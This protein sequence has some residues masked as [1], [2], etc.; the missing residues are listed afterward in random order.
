MNVSQSSQ[1]FIGSGGEV[2]ACGVAEVEGNMAGD[3]GRDDA[4]KGRLA[5][6]VWEEHT[7]SVAFGREI[8]VSLL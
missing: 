4:G 7:V 5:R 3:H 8:C 1:Q 6:S 2:L